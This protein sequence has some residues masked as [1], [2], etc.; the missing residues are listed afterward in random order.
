MMVGWAIMEEIEMESRKGT[1][2]NR[3]RE[4]SKILSNLILPKPN[5]LTLFHFFTTQKK[6]K[7]TH[8]IYILSHL[9]IILSI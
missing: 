1:T 8:S 9:E 5:F 7:Y 4:L 2:E 6:K 3:A